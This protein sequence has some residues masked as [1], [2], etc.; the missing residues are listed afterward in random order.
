MR[1]LFMCCYR[2]VGPVAEVVGSFLQD[3]IH[4][5]DQDRSRLRGDLD[6]H[7]LPELSPFSRHCLS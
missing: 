6:A 1:K 4:R 5:L 7:Y 3:L 2:D